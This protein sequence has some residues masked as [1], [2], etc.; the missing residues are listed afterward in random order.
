MP[1]KNTGVLDYETFLR[2]GLDL[3]NLKIVNLA[4]AA[5]DF[6]FDH[7]HDGLSSTTFRS[8]RSNYGHRPK[9][10][11]KA[12][13]RIEDEACKK[14]YKAAH[15]FWALHFMK[16]YDIEDNLAAKFGVTPK[17]FRK[18][19]KQL[20]HLLSQEFYNLVSNYFFLF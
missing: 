17:T 2:I 10:V 8:W 4:N 16:S 14:R 15:F 3:A 1:Q 5:D 20:M 12:W 7:A 9:V 13:R 11:L 18:R 6:A 19:V